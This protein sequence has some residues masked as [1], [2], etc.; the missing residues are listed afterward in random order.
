LNCKMLELDSYAGEDAGASRILV[1]EAGGSKERAAAE[2][3]AEG[4]RRGCA[5]DPQN[6]LSVGFCVEHFGH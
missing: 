4:M 5:Q 2:R 1:V 6:L 3:R